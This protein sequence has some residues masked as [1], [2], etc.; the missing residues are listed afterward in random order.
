MCPSRAEHESGGRGRAGGDVLVL[1]S[2]V[3]EHFIA[4]AVHVIDLGIGQAEEDEQ[5]ED[6]P[7]GPYVGLG[8]QLV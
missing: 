1:P 8:R 4:Q 6:H 7:E 5:V 3:S 2:V